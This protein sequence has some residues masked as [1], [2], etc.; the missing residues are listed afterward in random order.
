MAC[1]L[2]VAAVGLLFGLALFVGDSAKAGE[3][4]SVAG[5]RGSLKAYSSATGNAEVSAPSKSEM[6]GRPVI[7]ESNGR[8]AIDVGGSV[9][10]IKKH[11][12]RLDRKLAV[13]EGCQEAATSFAGNSATRGAGKGCAE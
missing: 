12:V 2:G 13:P 7:E 4:G 9:I 6:K 3:L 1:R 5:I 10:W 11:Q 8:Y